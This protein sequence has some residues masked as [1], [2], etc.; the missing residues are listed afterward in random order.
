MRAYPT[1][2]VVGKDGTIIGGRIDRNTFEDEL[3]QALG[4]P[5]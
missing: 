3:K 4:L 5:D 2:Y 1:H